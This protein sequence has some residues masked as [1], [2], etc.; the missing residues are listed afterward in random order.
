MS[1]VVRATWVHL[2]QKTA[3]GWTPR[4]MNIP[5]RD[6][7]YLVDGDDLRFIREVGTLTGPGKPY[8]TVTDTDGGWTIVRVDRCGY[9]VFE[10]G[11]VDC[12]GVDE[13]PA[14]ARALIARVR[15]YELK[16]R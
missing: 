4:L 13:D 10:S 6:E 14:L 9:R 12:T 16:G 3:A 15:E 2:L 11:F 5:F 1:R 8:A 7:S